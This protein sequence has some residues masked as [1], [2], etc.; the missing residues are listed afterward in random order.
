MKYCVKLLGLHR[1]KG[2]TVWLCSSGSELGFVFSGCAKGSIILHGDGSIACPNSRARYAVYLN[3]RELESGLLDREEKEIALPM[4]EK[5]NGK[6]RV[7]KLSEGPRSSLGVELSGFDGR[8]RPLPERKRKIEFIGDSITCG[9]GV[10]GNLSNVFS[11]ATED[12]RAAYA[13]IAASLLRADACYSCYSGFG[14]V[15]GYTGDGVRNAHDL[16]PLYWKKT[17]ICDFSF[18]DGERPD[19]TERDF[20]AFCPDTVVINLGT[21]DISYTG[22]DAAR[23]KEYQ[24]EYIAFLETVRAVYPEAEIVCVLGVMGD[25]LNATAEEAVKFYREKTGDERVRFHA[26]PVQSPRDGLG[27]DSHPSPRTQMKTGRLAA[28]LLR[29]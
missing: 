27:T 8:V 23:Q 28:R 16:V 6:V 24:R 25:T 18:P 11:T 5:T 9:Y 26:L 17:G 7:V 21:N 19:E 2:D 13:Y 12:V 20:S 4:G 29:G 14:L 1:V 3:G 22:E 10:D 15:S